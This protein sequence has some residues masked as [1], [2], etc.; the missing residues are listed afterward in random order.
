MQV[1]SLTISFHLPI[2]QG[3]LTVSGTDERGLA[4]HHSCSLHTSDVNAVMGSD[5]VQS[6]VRR[7]LAAQGPSVDS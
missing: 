3:F 1:E 7:V 5:V 4:A 2:G 6:L